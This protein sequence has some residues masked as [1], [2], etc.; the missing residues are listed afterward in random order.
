MA[1]RR[2]FE[3][4][5]NRRASEYEEMESRRRPMVEWSKRVRRKFLIVITAVAFL[6]AT[7]SA[8]AGSIG[9]FFK[10][11]GN[12]IVH[13][14][15]KKKSKPRD[16]KMASKRSKPKGAAPNNA[17]FPPVP[18]ETP[19]PPP[20][21]TTAPTQL[22]VRVASVS[23]KTK[24]TKRDIPYAIPVPNKPGFVTSPYAPK[25]GLVDVRGFPSGTEVIDPYSGKVFLTP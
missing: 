25:Q 24:S 9:D 3:L 6:A 8:G 17:D 12:S 1:L 2:Y 18:P 10:A 19:A 23:A 14:G 13:P 16:S 20:T 11:L 4:L 5:A 22:P 21:P 7:D 15:Q